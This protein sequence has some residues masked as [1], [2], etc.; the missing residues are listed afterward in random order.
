MSS[1]AVLAVIGTLLGTVLGALLQECLQVRRNAAT[2]RAYWVRIALDWATSGRKMSLRRANLQD[3]D[4]RGLDVA[5][6]ADGSPN[7]DLSYASLQRAKLWNAKMRGVDLTGADMRRA[8]LTGADLSDSDLH[9]ADLRRA[10]LAG[11]DLNDA[12][13]PSARLTRAN[14]WNAHLRKADLTGA[15]LTSADLFEASLEGSNLCGTDLTDAWMERI[16]LDDARYDEKTRWP[17]DFTP[18]PQTRNVAKQRGGLPVFW[19]EL[20]PSRD[21]HA[22]LR[23]R[24]GV[25]ARVEEVDDYSEEENSEP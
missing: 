24:L 7:A 17:R 1:E 13:L 14:L 11:A 2:E 6:A 15:D 25:K 22:R 23:R 18:P 5:Q 12:R 4:L 8:I 16:S 9:G 20:P 10:V 19:P 3:A 21:W